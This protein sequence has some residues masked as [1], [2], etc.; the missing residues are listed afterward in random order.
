MTDKAATLYRMVLPDHTCPFG[1]HAKE[2]LEEAGFEVEDRILRTRE[3]VDAFEQEQGVD[4]TPQVF[5][6]G[7]RIGGSDESGLESGGYRLLRQPSGTARN[8]AVGLW[9]LNVPWLA[10][11]PSCSSGKGNSARAPPPRARWLLPARPMPRPPPRWTAPRP[12]WPCR[13]SSGSA[14][15]PARRTGMGA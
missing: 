1:V 13:S 5:I 15:H 8:T 6:D 2:L 10:A 11:G 3:E 9:L 4:A 12:G 7:D 14:S